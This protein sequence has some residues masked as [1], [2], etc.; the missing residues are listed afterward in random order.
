MSTVL[1]KLS[2]TQSFPYSIAIEGATF[3]KVS[4]KLIKCLNFQ[5]KK[6]FPNIFTNKKVVASF[7][8]KNCVCAVI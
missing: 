5:G 3:L 2:L 6:K 8:Q 4:G 1:T 7:V